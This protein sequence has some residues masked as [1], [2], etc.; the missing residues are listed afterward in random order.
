MQN[1]VPNYKMS[2]LVVKYETRERERITR[3]VDLKA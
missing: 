3:G 2:Y 1:N